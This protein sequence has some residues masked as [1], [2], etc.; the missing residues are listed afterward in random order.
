MKHFVLI[1]LT[2]TALTACTGAADIKSSGMTTP[3]TWG[4]A[5]MG[6]AALTVDANAQ[7]DHQWWTHFSDPALDALIK[8][9]LQNNKT[10]AI[11]KARVEEAQALRRSA[12]SQLMPQINGTGSLGRANQ[13]VLANDAPVSLGQANVEASWEL[14]LFG[15]NQARVRE[16]AAILESEDASRQ[17]VMVGLLAE[18]ARTYFDLRN[19]ATQIDI[20]KRN[21]DTQKKTLTLIDAQL[22]GALAS[23]FD[24]QRAGAQVS[25]TEALIPTLQTAYD[26]SLNRLNVLLG[27]A[28]GAP[29]EALSSQAPYKPLD[30]KIVVSAPATVLAARPDVRAAERRF[31][32]AVS[33]KTAAQL[34]IFPRISL[35]GLFGVQDTG[36]VSANPWSLGANLVQPIF[37]FGRIQSQIDAAD[38]REQQAFLGYQQSILEALEDME[39]ALSGYLNETARNASLN[40]SVVQNRKATELARQQ[41]TSGYAALLDVLVAERNVLDAES[42]L[43]FSDA[44]LRTDLVGIYT[45][46][47]GGWDAASQQ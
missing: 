3:A 19:N 12:R 37:N 25:T 42:A 22:Q 1:L 27:R 9:A 15:Q 16:A 24:V 41:Y 6:D 23:D 30:T 43:A 11:A 8:E 33:A 5:G 36:D 10:L 44:K 28:P 31:A 45:A 13:G 46:A 7:T 38:A 20:T 35:L 17:A 29:L 39:N 32:A 34:D 18:V 26:A 4:K 21:L 2:A 14:D 47:G 40:K